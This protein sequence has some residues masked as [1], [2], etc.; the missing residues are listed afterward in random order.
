MQISTI[1][2]YHWRSMSSTWAGLAQRL[3]RRLQTTPTSAS[4]RSVTG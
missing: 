4:R 3:W 2:T 1:T